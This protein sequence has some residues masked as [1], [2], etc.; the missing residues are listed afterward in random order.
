M[1][2]TV[3]RQRRVAHAVVVALCLGP[4]LALVW[5]AI[6]DDL[7]ANP[8]ETITHETGEWTLRFLVLTLSVTPVRRLL[9]FPALAP[10]RRTFGLTAF[11]YACLHFSTYVGLDLGL[12]LGAAFE[13][14][15]ERP[16]ITMGFTAFL[17]MVPL[18]ATSGA[19]PSGDSGC[20]G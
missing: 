1:A 12:E 13:D 19:P 18:A 17:L 6:S 20:V 16:Y 11:G 7:G 2:T 14:I 5:A 10:Y 4:A 8:I 3:R 9:R 15:L